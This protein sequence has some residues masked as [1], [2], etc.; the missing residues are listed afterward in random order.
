MTSALSSQHVHAPVF[1]PSGSAAPS[2]KPA[3]ARLPTDLVNA[4]VF[5]PK[6]SA[7]APAFVPASERKVGS[8]SLA[9]NPTAEFVP[10]SAASQTEDSTGQTEATSHAQDYDAHYLDATD[11]GLDYYGNGLGALSANAAQTR[12]TRQP[13]N[14]HLYAPALPH[15]ANLTP[16]QQAVCGFFMS[17]TLREDLHLKSDA[18]AQGISPGEGTEIGGYWGFIPLDTNFGR[19][20][21]REGQSPKG[22][23]G[24]KTWVYKAGHEADG[25]YYALRRVENFRL[26]HEA[27]LTVV[28]KWRRIAHPNIVG[29]REAYTTHGFGDS[30]LIFVYDFH[31]LASTLHDHHLLPKPPVMRPNGRLGP[32]S[33]QIPERVLWSYIIQISSAIRAAHTAGLALR[34]VEISKILLT[35]KNRLRVNCCSMFDVLRFENDASLEMQQQ[36]DLFDLG[37]LIV[38][39]GCTSLSAV[40]NLPRSLDH[41]SRQ[42]SNDIKNLVLFLFGKPEPRKNIDEV[43]AMIGPRLLDDLNASQSENDLLETE[44]MREL[45]N[46]RL[47]RLL[48]KFGFINE[49]PEFDHDPRWSETG[50]RYLIKLFRDYVFHQVEEHGHP[51]VDL[52]HVLTCLNKLDAGVDEKMTLVSRDGQSCLIVSYRDL[53]QAVNAAFR[54]LAR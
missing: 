1:V 19:Q 33:T 25:R 2:P 24:H 8:S 21:P 51:V 54:D 34:T 27:A 11:A 42:Y 40:H 23:F 30:S 43:L 15:V 29:I 53:K 20:T 49:R 10:R 45:E 14:Y 35:G 50:D 12:F 31:P 6:S 39:L 46:A 28:E 18:I 44:L 17:P 41:L 9:F 32:A 37:K 22:F 47:V 52:S 16:Q 5:V 3:Q 38:T 26:P 48:C 36:E 13:L 4:P 7:A